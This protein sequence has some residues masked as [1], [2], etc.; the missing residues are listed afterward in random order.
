MDKNNL[1]KLAERCE[2]AVGPDRELDADI[3]IAALG[4]SEIPS[5]EGDWRSLKGPS[6][7]INVTRNGSNGGF[8]GDKLPKFTAS[9]DAAMTLVPE[10]WRWIMRQARP[11]KANPNEYGYFARLETE[12]FES[13]TW[14]K[15]SDWLT[16]TVAGQDV[17]VWAGTPALALCAAALRSHARAQPLEPKD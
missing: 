15:G 4:W 11:D 14:G 2:A 10:G 3:C 9:L 8:A 16:D 1:V 7:R 17:F 13:V 12:D 5:E 6:G